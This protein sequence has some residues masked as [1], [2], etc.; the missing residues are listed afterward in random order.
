MYPIRFIFIALKIVEAKRK[1]TPI[2][3]NKCLHPL[4]FNTCKMRTQLQWPIIE[5][6]GTFFF[7]ESTSSVG[8]VFDCQ[9][10]K[11]TTSLSQHHHSK[12]FQKTLV[13]CQYTVPFYSLGS[14]SIKDLHKKLGKMSNMFFLFQI[15]SQSSKNSLNTKLFCNLPF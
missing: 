1:T 12:L 3:T 4:C 6:C 14:Q 9:L 15:L 13:M 11:E 2:R 5:L 7:K 10:N 8:T